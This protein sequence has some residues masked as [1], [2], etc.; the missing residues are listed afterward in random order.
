MPTNNDPKTEKNYP[1][2]ISTI[3]NY[4]K[5]IEDYLK[6]LENK[7]LLRFMTCGSVDDG[8]STLIGR[9]LYDTKM[10]FEDQLSQLKS[11]S[12]K[13]GTVKDEEIDFALL[14]DGLQSERQQGITID[15]A[16]RYFSTEKRKYIIADAPGHEQYT[17]NMVTG[18]SNADLAVILVDARKGVLTQTKR[19]SFIVGLL[20]INHIV[21]TVNKMDLVDYSEDVFKKIVSAYT[22]MFERLKLALP[23]KS[24]SPD[25]YFIPISALKG[26]NV[27]KESDNMPWYKGK[28]LLEYLDTVEIKPLGFTYI[29]TT[30]HEPESQTNSYNSTSDEG[31]S[32]SNI[33][34]SKSYESN[35]TSKT[36]PSPEPEPEPEPPASAGSAWRQL[37]SVQNSSFLASQPLRFPIQYINR[38][39]PDFRGY[40]GTIVSGTLSNDDE[41]IIYPSMKE[42]TIKAI[43]PPDYKEPDIYDSKS[44]IQ[45]PKSHEGNPKS[46]IQ[47][48]EFTIQNSKFK[49]QNPSSITS[50]SS[51]APITILV[52]DELDIS[53]GDLIVKKDELPPRV[54]DSFEAMIVWMDEEPLKNREYILRIY[55]KETNAIVSRILF[56][57]DVNTLEKMETKTLELNDI[58][59]VQI[60]LTEKIAFD[61]YEKN[62]ST[63]AFM[64]IDK[65]TNNT[66]AAGMIVGESTKKKKRRVYTQAEI[67]LNRFI[68]E[69]FPEWECKAIEEIVGDSK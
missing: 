7:E 8:K 60:D 11:E 55:T 62:K 51:P 19:H 63:G 48:Q 5:T 36:K 65:I 53:R 66:S 18:A 12:K 46:N 2:T 26:D 33:Q 64:L 16:Y 41:I 20:G 34:N 28:S 27:A 42:T 24:Y 21:I 54:S 6:R 50:S 30:D 52:S 44:R 4:S 1:K 58:A 47:N 3:P 69:H 29:K 57:R 35:S 68:R 15:V 9:L 43:I 32:K 59:R 22:N 56:K 67:A 40:S 31:N 14:V 49:I 61:F 37:G 25:I 38:P 13:Y 39:T 23:Y 45:N 10:I 17:R